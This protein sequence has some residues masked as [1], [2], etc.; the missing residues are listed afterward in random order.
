MPSPAAGK[1]ALR[2]GRGVGIAAH[3]SRPVAAGGSAARRPEEMG[4]PRHGS[5]AAGVAARRCKGDRPPASRGS[6][7]RQPNAEGHP[8]GRAGFRAHGGAFP[9]SAAGG[10]VQCRDAR[11]R[12]VSGRSRLRRGP[13]RGSRQR[14]RRR[15]R[16]GA[17]ARRRTPCHHSVARRGP[18]RQE[19]HRRPD[20]EGET[21]RAAGRRPAGGRPDPHRHHRRPRRAP[22][23]GRESPERAAAEAP[24]PRP[25]ERSGRERRERQRRGPP[26]RRAAGLRLRAPVPRRAGSRPRHRRLRAGGEAGRGSVH[27]AHRRRRAAVAGPHRLHARPA[28]RRAR[29]RRDGAAVPRQSRLARRHRAV[30]EVRGGPLQGQ[31][32]GPV[33]HPHRGGAAGEPP[34]GRVPRRT[35]PAAAVHRLHA[36]LPQRGGVLRG[37]TSAG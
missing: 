8:P 21:Q 22:R 3:D 10:R 13:S 25:R 20:R 4:R 26:S 27:R 15:A 35:G 5:P 11:S 30:A 29:L 12:V 9:R 19:D 36:V 2:I 33:P 17:P 32:L 31:G 16:G 34:P 7:R 23:G 18:P 6:R 1:T 28:H 14:P 37:P 24:E